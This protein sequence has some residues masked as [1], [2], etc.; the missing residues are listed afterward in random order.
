M[1]ESKNYE[2]LIEEQF[3]L[4]FDLEPENEDDN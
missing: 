3:D 2:T 4:D 1:T